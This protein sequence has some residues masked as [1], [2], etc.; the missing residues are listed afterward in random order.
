MESKDPQ[1]PIMKEVSAAAG[2]WLERA[3]AP[4]PAVPLGAWQ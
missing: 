2:T 1:D 3:R 4:R